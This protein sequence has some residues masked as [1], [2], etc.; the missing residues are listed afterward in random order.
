MPEYLQQIKAILEG[1]GWPVLEGAYAPLL[2]DYDNAVLIT[3][4]NLIKREVEQDPEGLRYIGN[5]YEDVHKL[6]TMP[7]YRLHSTLGRKRIVLEAGSTSGS[8]VPNELSVIF[9]RV[10]LPLAIAKD[11]VDGVLRGQQI[12]NF[13][14][15]FT[16]DTL[17]EAL[18]GLRRPIVRVETAS[19]IISEPLPINPE[20][21]DTIRIFGEL[22]ASRWD[23][24][25]VGVPH[26]P[27]T[28]TVDDVS[29]AL[30]RRG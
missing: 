10:N 6:L 9:G 29:T 4:Y 8:Y 1:F 2:V 23:E 27:S 25:N 26:G 7:Y 17:T 16:K 22:S 13:S 5:S 18:R 28:V 15:R 12:F 11:F 21:G 24:L 19:L 14:F 30:K 20:A 3:I